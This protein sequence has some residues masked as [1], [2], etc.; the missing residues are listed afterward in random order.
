LG[1]TMAFLTGPLLDT[2]K[3]ASQHGLAAYAPHL[4]L[5][6]GAM[7]AVFAAYTA[8]ERQH[9]F[10]SRAAGLRAA[11]EYRVALQTSLVAQEMDFHLKHGSGAL[12]GR[13][14]NDTNHLS[15]KNVSSRLSMFIDAVYLIVGVSLLMA[16]SP[17][18]GAVV[19]VVAPVLGWVNAR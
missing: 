3:L 4:A 8:V 14:L 2:A 6:S 1:I 7:L 11:A 19:L 15:T 12:S 9:A 16:T 17:S 10:L 13:L 5:L 18:I